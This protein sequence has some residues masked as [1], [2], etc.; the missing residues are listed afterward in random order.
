MTN[1]NM[2]PALSE[3]ATSSDSSPCSSVV[4]SSTSW[5]AY[6]NLTLARTKR[7][8]L[9]KRSA[10]KGPL[11]VQKPF[12]PEGRD[13]AHLYLLHPPGGMVSGDRL[14]VTCQ[15]GERSRVL[16]TTP[17][18]GRVYKARPDRALQRQT[19]T[20]N[21]AA[22]GSMEWLPQETILYPDAHTRLDTQVNLQ[23]NAQF[24][25]WEVTSFGLP[26][27]GQGFDAGSVNQCLRIHQ[28]GK[29]VLQE[30]LVVS[31]KNR[32]LMAQLA[33]MNQ[34]AING[35]MVAGPFEVDTQK[36]N[37]DPQETLLAQLKQLCENLNQTSKKAGEK[38]M[39]AATLVGEFVV[40]RYLGADSEQAKNLFIQC[41]QDIRPVLLQRPACPPRIW[42]T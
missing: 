33:G 34:Q 27:C 26:A 25:G 17:G 40:I 2:E 9:L 5:H 21:V 31:P 42:A 38:T 22:D 36:V 13:L 29:L 35:F 19:I 24:I 23:E 8:V 28:Q 16:I 14:E 10:H 3:Q 39:A 1:S 41:W 15:Q 12:Y 4:S 11:Y 6:L 20:L 30:R 37:S 7:G 18:A 32:Q